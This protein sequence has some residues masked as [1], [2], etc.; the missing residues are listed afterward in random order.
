[1]TNLKKRLSVEQ[2]AALDSGVYGLATL[3]LVYSK[4][5]PVV[6]FALV[7]AGGAWLTDISSISSGVQVSIPAWVRARATAVNVLVYCA[8]IGLGSLVWGS[9]ASVGGIS[10][11]LNIAACILIVSAPLYLYFGLHWE[12]HFD[13]SQLQRRPNTQLRNISLDQGPVLV[14]VEYHIDPE[15]QTEFLNAAEKL[16]RL[17]L[18]DGATQWGVYRDVTDPARHI[19]TF[20][21]KSWADHLRLHSRITV[22]DI[23][24]E[25]FVTSFHLSETEPFVNHFI[26]GWSDRD[27]IYKK[28][29]NRNQKSA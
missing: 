11:A 5:L 3:A 6:M 18:R 20:L 29:K 2:I 4:S 22:A 12:E 19:E 13:L 27:K 7:V 26:S 1:L 24:I 17:R 9:I 25:E 16:R 23:G 21:V 10:F 15:R 8:S 28:H 14:T